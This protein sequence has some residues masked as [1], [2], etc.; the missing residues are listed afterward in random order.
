MKAELAK[1]NSDKEAAS[2]SSDKYKRQAS[3]L[4]KS[5]KELQEKK[6][7]LADRFKHKSGPLD[8]DEGRVVD[9]ITLVIEGSSFSRRLFR[10]LPISFHKLTC[11]TSL[12]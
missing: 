5:V 3:D 1:A 11:F 6:K 8:V 9:A 4:H 7:T 10:V 2:T 12:R